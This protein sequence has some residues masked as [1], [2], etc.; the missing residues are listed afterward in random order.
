MSNR[1]GIAGMV[2]AFVATLA[3][4]VA[5]A[6][7]FPSQLAPLRAEIVAD[8]LEHPWGLVLLS[9]DEAIVTER[10]G[11]MRILSGGK[12]SEPIAG[13]PE[14]AVFGQG[15]L[16]DVAIAP[17]FA[18][19]GIIFFTYA[20]PGQGG[21]STAAARAKLVRNGADAR[22]EAV[23]TIFSMRRKTDDGHHF[24]SRVVVRPD[25]MLH[26]TT[27]D[28][29]DGPR[30][31]DLFD[32][33]GAVLRINADGSIPA[34]NPYADG[35]AGAPEIWSKGH[36]NLQG[37]TIDPANGQLLTTEHGAK[38]GDEIN[39]PQAGKNY[40]WP[41]ITYGVNYNGRKI[42]VGTEAP[43]MEQP[44]HYWD[45]SI[46]PS[47]LVVYSGNMFPEWKG[48]LLAGSL[49]FQ[50]LSRLDRDESGKIV[51]EE[52]MLEGAFGRVRDVDQAP[53]GSIWLITDEDNGSIVRIARGG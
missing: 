39:A 12:L 2:T 49:K 30:A 18:Q 4:S 33:A 1:S 31:Q 11:R 51:G 47:G 36:R 41:T 9:N 10:P 32:T 29:G 6:Q 7:D 20:E 45:P 14:V 5:S 50:L 27:G 24:G 38:G 16:L 48:D 8:G 17:D 46:A 43:G 23:K 21:A 34:D 42:G 15:G 19:S 3:G 28:R 52:R 26:I 40:G 13:V 37:A 53:D 44:L 25:G 35:K 22:L